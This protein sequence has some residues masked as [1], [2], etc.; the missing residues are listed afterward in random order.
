MGKHNKTLRLKK[1]VTGTLFKFNGNP[2]DF[3]IAVNAAGI[4]ISSST[5]NYVLTHSWIWGIN[6]NFVFTHKGISKTVNRYF[7]NNQAMKLNILGDLVIEYQIESALELG[8]HWSFSH[9]T[10]EAVILG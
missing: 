5:M 8:D 9:K 4:P 10:W 1:S 6:V 3:Q 2:E 7:K